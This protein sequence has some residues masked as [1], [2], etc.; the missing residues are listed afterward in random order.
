[1]DRRSALDR[2]AG[3]GSSTAAWR[4]RAGRARTRGGCV[5]CGGC[6]ERDQDR[7]RTAGLGLLLLPGDVTCGCRRS[8]S[9]RRSG[10]R[11]HCLRGRW[12]NRG[13]GL[14]NRARNALLRNTVDDD[15]AGHVRRSCGRR[16]RNTCIRRGHREWHRGGR[17]RGGRSDWLR[18]GT[19][20][21]HTAR[22]TNDV[23]RRSAPVV[24]GRDRHRRCC[25]RRQCAHENLPEEGAPRTALL[26]GQPPRV[27]RIHGA[28]RR[29][30]GCAA[31]ALAHT[32][33]TACRRGR[34]RRQVCRAQPPK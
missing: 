3:D 7:E 19:R 14:Q 5:G 10:L 20:G 2:T 12:P 21:R 34:R 15:R 17:G 13:T 27:G 16:L 18:E 30:T 24:T 1:M 29:C 6:G 8:A 22:L 23:L 32:L 26:G 33:R 28:Q 11:D 25:R 31:P 4:A 9:G